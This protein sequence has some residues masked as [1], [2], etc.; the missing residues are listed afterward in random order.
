M[1]E[2][3]VE[4][5]RAKAGDR[6]AFDTLVRRHQHRLQ[7]FAIRMAGGDAA[8]GA[9]VTVGVFVRL[10]E[11]RAAYRPEGKLE[12]WLLRAAYRMIVDAARRERRS[13]ALD[14]CVDSR[15]DAHL[16]FERATHAEAIRQAIADLPEGQRAVVVLSVYEELTQEAIA[17]ALGIPPGTV[18]SRKAH[19][20]RTLRRRLAAWEDP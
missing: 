6:V 17:E 2:D 18:A 9:D 5:E 3:D 1:N 10:W 16:A 15:R 8:R 11:G 7:R 20:L 14:E 13:A 4:M 19:A 12:A